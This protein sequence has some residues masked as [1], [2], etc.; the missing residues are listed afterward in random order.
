MSPRRNVTER[1]LWD[2]LMESFPYKNVT[3]CRL[4]LYIEPPAMGRSGPMGRNIFRGPGLYNLDLSLGKSWKIGERLG[5]QLRGEFFNVLNHPA[6]SNPYS[7][8]G[9]FFQM[10]PLVPGSFGCACATPDVAE[11]NPVIGS[12]GPR[13]IQVGLKFIFLSP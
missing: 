10:D 7:V 6:L 11:A 13:N 1:Y 3:S 2:M 8:N 4:R 5:A 12:V 9:T